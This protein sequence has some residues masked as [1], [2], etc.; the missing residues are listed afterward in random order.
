MNVHVNNVKAKA[1]LECPKCH[2]STDALCNC[3]VDYMFVSA[4]KRAAEAVAANPEKSDRA[5]AAATGLSHETVRTARKATGKNLTVERRIG[6]DGKTRRAPKRPM[7]V[8]DDI[9]KKTETDIRAIE[10]RSTKLEGLVEY[11][12]Q[13]SDDVRQLLADRLKEITARSG[14]LEKAIR[15]LGGRRRA[16]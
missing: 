4:G 5:I 1:Q 7:G 2:A 14:K 3:G 8:P 15:P 10:D 11:A 9:L 16:R 13:I 6:R 12:D